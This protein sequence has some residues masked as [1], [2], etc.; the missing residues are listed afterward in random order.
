MAGISTFACAGLARADWQGDIQ[1]KAP[2]A[3]AP[4]MSGKAFGKLG[5]MRMDMESPQG[6]MS[7]ITD[8]KA[9]KVWML[10]HARK[11]VMEHGMDRAGVDLPHCTSDDI[12]TC[13]TREGFKKTG[14]E[15]VNGHPCAIYEADRET[16]GRKSHHKLWRP[17]DLKEVPFVRAA[18]SGGNGETGQVDLLNAKVVAALDASLFTPP[19]DY[20]PMSMPTGMGAPGGGAPVGGPGAG[21]MTPEQA[22]KLRDEMLKKYGH[23][24]GGN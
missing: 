3:G 21:G 19:A 23:P 12:D 2:R 9:R 16:E 11:M 5:A 8:W 10:M 14:S 17:T 7:A 15:T 6:K 24:A 13:L 18:H 4:E 22:M 1:M 20:K